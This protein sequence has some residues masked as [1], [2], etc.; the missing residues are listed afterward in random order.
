MDS[1]IFMGLIMVVFMLG[2]VAY[3]IWD[4]K[5]HKTKGK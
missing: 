4:E 5:K 1:I 3:V 2:V